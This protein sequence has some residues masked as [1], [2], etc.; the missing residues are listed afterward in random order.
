MVWGPSSNHI[1]WTLFL[2][3]TFGFCQDFLYWSSFFDGF[4]CYSNST[5][6][7][8]NQIKFLLANLTCCVRFGAGLWLLTL[9][10]DMLHLVIKPPSLEWLYGAGSMGQL[11]KPD[12]GV[13]HVGVSGREGAPTV[14]LDMCVLGGSR[15][16]LKGL[17]YYR[18][19]VEVL[20]A[21]SV[22]LSSSRWKIHI[23]AFIPSLPL[24]LSHFL[25]NNWT[26]R[27]TAH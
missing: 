20:V 14:P 10:P 13:P 21:G 2:I 27:T 6:F 22:W 7:W 9:L 4:T 18:D 25:S 17:G 23:H 8:T 1:C 15:R 19:P 26:K 12:L 16:W 3:I 11:V 24:S 5:V